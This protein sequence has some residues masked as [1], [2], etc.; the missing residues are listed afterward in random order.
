MSKA[1]LK[2]YLLLFFVILLPLA[3][4]FLVGNYG[5]RSEKFGKYGQGKWY[6]KY[7]AEFYDEF[8]T[9]EDDFTTRDK[10][11]RALKYGLNSHY[12]L[13]DEEPIFSQTIENEKGEKLF[14]LEIYRAIFEIEKSDRAEYLFTMYDVQYLK[15]RECFDVDSGV[16]QEIEKANVPGIS[17]KIFKVASDGTVVRSPDSE[18]G[19]MTISDMSSVIPDYDADVDF[20]QGYSGS[21][22]KDTDELVVCPLGFHRIPDTDWNETDKARLEIYASVEDVL[23]EN[24]QP[25]KT[26][27]IELDLEGYYSDPANFDYEDWTESYRQMQDP[28]KADYFRWVFGHYLWWISLIAFGLVGLITFSFYI[29]WVAENAYNEKAAGKAKRK[30]LRK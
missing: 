12:K 8:F 7:R 22:R 25:I 26:T 30:R 10:I 3:A 21:K 15:L 28:D 9:F 5:Y 4:A 29:F 18:I 17:A 6:D 23:D 20:K 2:K 14:V 16:K 1:L 11:L 27:V 13:Y 24:N 19:F